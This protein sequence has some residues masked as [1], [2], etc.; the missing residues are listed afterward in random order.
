MNK[1]YTFLILISITIGLYSCVPAR[2][3][4]ETEA[5]LKQCENDMS[6]AKTRADELEKA[7][8]D[9]EKELR[10]LK[11]ANTALKGDTTILGTSLRVMKIQY[12][13]INDLNREIQ[14]QLEL[15]RKGSEEDSK[16]L[17]GDLEVTRKELLMKEESLK[18]T[19]RELD[20]KKHDL[21]D[22]E[23]RIKELEAL[24]AKKDESVKALQKLIE[25]ALLSFKD[26]GLT[27]ETKNGKVYVSMEA[28]L[29]FASG[30]Y[31]VDQ[32]GKEALIKL[33]KILETQKDLE[34]LIEGHTDTDALKSANVPT[35]NW[36][37]SVLR[38][39]SVAKLM[40]KESKMEPKRITAAGRSEFVPISTDKAKN[41]R[42]EIILIP[43]LDELYKLIEEKK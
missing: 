28:K 38:S 43:N 17:A 22:R 37:L 30:K 2:K 25:D 4:E 40:L 12:D 39:T 10:T 16:K 19:E 23:K 15:L 32:E 9:M 26:K 42:I 41:R 11:E 33:A 24:I 18:L 6:A 13:K 1:L 27:V 21:E 36:E 20:L 35:D 29:L 7:S 8:K 5:K 3:L 34:V 31:N 14:R